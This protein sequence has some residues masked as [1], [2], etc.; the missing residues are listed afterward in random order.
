LVLSGTDVYVSANKHASF[1]GIV[2]YNYFKDTAMYWKNGTPVYIDQGDITAMAVAG[3]D[4]YLSGYIN[5]TTAVYWKNGVRTIL[6][7]NAL[8]TG[9]AASG[10]DVYVTG[11]ENGN[12]VYWKNGVKHILWTGSAT[13]VAIKNL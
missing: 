1:D 12:A 8:T 9:I 13:A 5:D 10:S 3:D 2:T 7:P 4:V 6:S 11:R